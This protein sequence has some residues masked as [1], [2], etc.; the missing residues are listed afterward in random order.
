[1]TYQHRLITFMYILSQ[2][3]TQR[4]GRRPFGIS[5]LIGGHDHDG[6]PNLYQTGR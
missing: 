6:S 2:K 4:G 5:T 3:Y 1:M